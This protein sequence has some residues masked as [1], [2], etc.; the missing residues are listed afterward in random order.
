MKVVAT[1]LAADIREGTTWGSL[2]NGANWIARTDETTS[3]S[4]VLG[5]G[6]TLSLEL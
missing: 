3:A 5:H 1:D 6:G 2:E 4:Q